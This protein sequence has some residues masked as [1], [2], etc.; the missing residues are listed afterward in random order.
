MINR[1]IDFSVENKF[2]LFIVVLAGCVFGWWSMKH[3]ALDAIPDLSDSQVIVYSRWDRSPNVI[4]DQVTYPIISALMGAPR[5]KAVRGFSDFG[6]SYVYAIFE[7]GTDIYWARSRTLEYLSSVLP[8]L[9]AGVKTEL[10][11]DASGLGWVFQYVL[12][13][14]DG[15]RSL[16]ELRSLQDWYLRYQLRSVKGVAEVASLGGYGQQYQVNLD[17]ARLQAYGISVTRVADA[18]R[19]G[20]S[21]VG[22]RLL[23]MGGT[24]Y[25]VRGRGYARSLEDFGNISVANV[26]ATPIRVKDLGVVT[27]G[28]DLRRGVAELDGRGEAVSGIV[29]M[30]QGENALEVIRR[31]KSK[32]RDIQTGLPAG[33]RVVSIYDR[34]ELIDRAIRNVRWTLIEV[35]FTVVLIILVFLWHF[36]SAA[37]PIVTIPATLLISF[38]PFRALGITANIMSLAG[39]AIAC[40]ALVDAAIVVVEQSHKKLES[41]D[42][43][44]GRAGYQ[45]VVLSAVK[46]VGPPTFFALLVIAVSFLPVFALEAQEGR[47][48]KPLAFTKTLA[49][50]IAAVLALTFDPALRVL[51]TRFSSY[52]FRPRW[53]CRVANWLLVGRVR[54]EESHPIS[55]RLMRVYEPVVRWS[56]RRKYWVIGGALTVVMLT[57][58]IFLKL[59]SEF[60]PPLNEGSI[61]FMPT[62][63]PGISIGEA[64]R[65][66]QITDRALREFPEV[67]HVLG[68]AGRAETSTDPAP[69]S[70]LETVIVLKPESKWRHVPTWYSRWSPEWIKPLFRHFTSDHISTEQLISQM[71]EKLQIPGIANSWTMPIKGRIDMLTTG[72]KTPLGIKISGSDLGVIEKLG[73]QIESV[74]PQIT[75]TRRAFA[76]RTTE[77]HFIDINWD[78]QE[79]ALRGVNLEDAQAVVRS[80]IGGE[81]VTMTIEGRE[82]Y[83]VNV[84]Y[85]RDF[86]SDVNALKRVLVPALGGQESVPL[87]DLAN[88]EVSTGPSMIRDEDGQLTGYVYVDLAGRDLGSYVEEA[89]RV[90]RSKV[91]VPVGY[92]ITW[93]GQFEAAQRVRQRLTIVVPATLLFIVL[94]LY[95]NT[96]SL[97]K[98]L[99]V[100]LAVPFSAV[101]AIWFVYLLGYNMSIAVWIG[102][103][104]LLGV[105]AETGVFMLLYLDLAYENARRQGQLKNLSGLQEAIVHGAARRL[106]PKFMTFATTCIGLIP[107]MW[108]TGTGSETMKR[109]A[110]PMVGGIFSSFILE[111]VVYPAVYQIWRSKFHLPGDVI[112]KAPTRGQDD[113]IVSEPEQLISVG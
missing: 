9:P 54:V 50:L 20:N 40:G 56:L 38:I 88:L 64:Q 93:S 19:E 11:P 28:P 36:P 69:L 66:L 41:W 55:R 90:I 8:T 17:P 112:T 45:D 87:S 105:D 70:M 52:N 42:R 35:V 4:E 82:R 106:R 2:L 85:M 1:V 73:M 32:L 48:F 26:N 62:T 51:L 79:L 63:M 68:K 67:D 7:D 74:L 29:V 47:M 75:G 72:I 110:A 77:G 100:V 109:I 58:P 43:A 6:Y 80:A 3:V 12:V 104:A 98:T 10:G 61:L 16:A 14:A 27:L 76:E 86:R 22:G 65:I 44:N 103:I 78:R 89:S 108:A 102:L 94:L 96:R 31:V 57:I 84:R 71:N 30:R 92:T 34:S 46:E 25:M 23:E 91:V 49:M 15:K 97:P 111:L 39:L 18:V 33:V 59:G 5:V 37:I 95:L 81:N 53:L 60:M 99:I 24:E 83:P 101:G 21:E 113:Q 13:D 107:I